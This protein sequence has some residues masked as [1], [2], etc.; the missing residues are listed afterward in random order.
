MPFVLILALTASLG[1]HAALLFGP[2]LELSADLE[3]EPLMAELK[4]MPRPP[5]Q[6]D[7]TVRHDRLKAA[8]AHRRKPDRL[9]S[10]SP[11][12][13]IN[14][15]S[16]LA[17]PQNSVPSGALEPEA[18]APPSPEI[19]A[20]PAPAPSEARLPERGTI[21]YRVDRGDSNFEIGFAQ[22]E[23]S[24]VDGHYR[25]S[26]VLETTGLVW[27]FKSIHI[28][29]E[30]RGLMTAA[31]LQPQTFVIRRNGLPARE[32]AYFDWERMTVSIADLGEQPLD[33]GAQD[34]LSFNYQLGYLAHPEAGSRLPIA[35]G[36]KY[37]IHRLEVLGDEDIELP[38]GL[39]RTLHLR[40]PGTNTTELWLAYDYLLLPVKIRHVDAKGDSFVQ[41][42]TKI[43]MGDERGVEAGNKHEDPN[44]R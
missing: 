33:D 36:K 15:A 35:T 14:G 11:L 28:E 19:V 24:I 29:M 27:L 30:S 38:A 26:S 16:P 42:A 37:G 32:T 21:R 44:Q 31:G 5:P 10:V 9:A 8:K 7:T 12:L 18:A 4:P 20:E 43:Q 25:L 41:V 34:L 23:W 40:A 17:I 1:L 22:H 39:M 6:V 13:S 2:E 3:S